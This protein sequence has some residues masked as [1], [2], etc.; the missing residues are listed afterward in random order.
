MMEGVQES[1]E[2]RLTINT[3]HAF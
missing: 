3:T 2:G 1:K